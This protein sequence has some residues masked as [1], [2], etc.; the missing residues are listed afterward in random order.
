MSE[1]NS[2]SQRKTRNLGFNTANTQD[3]CYAQ[4]EA[5]SSTKRCGR[6]TH[7]GP[8]ILPVRSFYLNKGGA[9]LQ[10]ACIDCDKKYRAD[11]AVKNRTV[12]GEKTT[13]EIY[14]MYIEKYGK[15]TKDCSKCK[16]SAPISE[17]R[18]SIGMECGLHNQCIPCSLKISQGNG[19][20]RDFIYQPDKDGINYKK[21]DNCERC[22]GTEYLAVDH[23]LPIAKG[24]TDC[25]SNKQTLCRPCNSKKCDTIDCV[26]TIEMLSARYRDPTLNFEDNTNL[27][28]IL[29][30][31]VLEFRKANIDNRSLSE[32]RD[33]VSRY[34]KNNNL[35]HNLERIVGKI[36]TI[37]NK[38]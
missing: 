18:P 25:I 28:R 38:S 31:R 32:I 15:D 20:L 4:I 26:V 30:K 3:E 22:A 14:K 24:G 16:R 17:F 23:I 9:T 35:G 6:N 11:R 34:I 19:G 21:K 36:A 5:E 7:E 27:S 1:V 13:E 33:C 37:F 10:G 2:K 29:A 12:Y 8:R